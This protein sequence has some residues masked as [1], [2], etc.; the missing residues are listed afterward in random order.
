MSRSRIGLSPSYHG[1]SGVLANDQEVCTEF[2]ADAW[3]TVIKSGFRSC[4]IYSFEYPAAL[5]VIARK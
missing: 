3:A 5:A 1:Q 4:E 2:G